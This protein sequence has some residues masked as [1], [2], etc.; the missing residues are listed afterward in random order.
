ML[1]YSKRPENGVASYAVVGKR[2]RVRSSL[3][4]AIVEYPAHSRK[5]YRASQSTQ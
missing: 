1:S 5:G 4:Q 3:L 2:S